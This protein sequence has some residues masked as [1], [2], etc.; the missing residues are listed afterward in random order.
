M[1]RKIDKNMKNKLVDIFIGSD[2]EA[3]YIASLLMDNQ[4]QCIIENQLEG[5]LS[6]GWVNGSQYNSSIIR[7]DIN[8]FEKAKK[9]ISE[10][11]KSNPTENQ[12]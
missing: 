11:Q 12:S 4:I 3:N 1:H 7:I 2:I 6:A 10:Y 5:S 9:V 8:D